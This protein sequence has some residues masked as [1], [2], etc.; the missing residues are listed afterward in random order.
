MGAFANRDEH[1]HTPMIAAHAAVGQHEAREAARRQNKLPP[2][3]LVAAVPVRIAERRIGQYV[4]GPEV[5]VQIEAE[6][7]G[8]HG[9]EVAFDAAKA[10][11]IIANLLPAAERSK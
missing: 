5:F 2:H 9:A 11:F 8:I 3:D 6:R 10:K 1:L 4:I 7:V